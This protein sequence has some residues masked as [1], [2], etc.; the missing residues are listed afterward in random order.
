LSK[1][2]LP[3]GY[4]PAINHVDYAGIEPELLQH[5]PGDKVSELWHCIGCTI[6]KISV[7]ENV[8]IF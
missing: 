2:I 1:Q 5:E 4:V 6:R 7:G 8:G 3:Q